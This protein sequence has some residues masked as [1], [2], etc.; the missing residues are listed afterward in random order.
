MLVGKVIVQQKKRLGEPVHQE[1]WE[2]LNR[3][4]RSEGQEEGQR[5]QLA[6]LS[7]CWCKIFLYCIETT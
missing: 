6:A 1:E 5:L 4:Y 7:A 3:Q 2:M